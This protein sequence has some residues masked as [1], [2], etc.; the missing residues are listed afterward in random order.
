MIRHFFTRQFLGFVA[1][2]GLAALLN[3]LSRFLLSAWLPFPWAVALAYCVGMGSAFVLNSR[4]VFPGS[5]RSRV[6]QARDF[7]LVNLAFFPVVMATSIA[8]NAWLARLGVPA[9]REGLA[10]AIAIAMPMLVT[11]LIYKFVAFKEKQV[12]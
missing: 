2:G 4:Y 8:V 6:L 10:H 3:W 9:Y 7:V 12:G 11:F 1:V 5:E